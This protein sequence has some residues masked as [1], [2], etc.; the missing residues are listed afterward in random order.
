MEEDGGAGRPRMH[1]EESFPSSRFVRSEAT[2]NL[3]ADES[4]SVLSSFALED[5][6]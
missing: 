1:F 2:L 5:L 3:C 4:L 6:P